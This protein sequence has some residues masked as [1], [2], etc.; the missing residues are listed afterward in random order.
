MH[1]TLNCEIG[2][3]DVRVITDYRARVHT[4]NTYIVTCH[5][6]VHL[7]HL[8]VS[9]QCSHTLAHI[10]TIYPYLQIKINSLNGNQGFV[11]C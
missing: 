10:H 6:L 8:G 11:V 1:Y 5:V 7:I 2:K 9:G 3:L 4:C